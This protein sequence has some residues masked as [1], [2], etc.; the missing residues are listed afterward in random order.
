MLEAGCGQE[1]YWSSKVVLI[2]LKALEVNVVLLL[3]FE[4]KLIYSNVT[5]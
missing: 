4:E 5:I 1:V 3:Q 2:V